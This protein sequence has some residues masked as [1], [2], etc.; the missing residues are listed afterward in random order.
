MIPTSAF[1]V[2]PDRTSWLARR[3]PA[4]R[5][6]G[7]V[8]SLLTCWLLPFWCVPVALML[9][10][11]LLHRRGMPPAEFARAARPWLGIVLLV[12]LVH[13]LTTVAA[14]PLGRPSWQGFGRGVAAVG[15]VAASTCCLVLFVRVTAIADLI[16]GLQWWCR[17]LRRWGF[18]AERLALVLT[19]AL[20]TVAGVQAEGRRIAAVV[21]LRRGGKGRRS[22]WLKRWW[23]RLTD[24]AHLVVPLLESLFRRS[25]TLT[26]SLRGRLPQIADPGQPPAAEFV[27]LGSWILMLVMGLWRLSA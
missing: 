9:L 22:A 14:A 15:R 24:A 7:L 16:A 20:G 5:L 25:E 26:L 2:D 17:P 6:L 21:R 18:Q 11:L 10:A 23:L 4:S 13:T 12:L 1:T 19:V 27:A 3:H 8:L